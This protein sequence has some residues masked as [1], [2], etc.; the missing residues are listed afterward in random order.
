MKLSQLRYYN[1]KFKILANDGYPLYTEAELILRSKE[2]LLVS[3]LLIE[4]LG[5]D[6]LEPML[7]LR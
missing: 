7:G 4:Y 1:Q 2:E 3:I 6:N 5:K